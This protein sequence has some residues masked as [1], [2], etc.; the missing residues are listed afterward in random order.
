[1]EIHSKATDEGRIIALQVGFVALVELLSKETPAIGQK[2]ASYLEETGMRPA[3][4]NSSAAF[5]ELSE[6]VRGMEGQR[7]QSR[8]DYKK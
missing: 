4:V 6:F 3:N 2:I 7:E 8:R 5:D 1:M